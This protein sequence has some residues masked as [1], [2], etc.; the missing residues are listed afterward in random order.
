MSTFKRGDLV[1]FTDRQGIALETRVRRVEIIRGTRYYA[2][3]GVG[4]MVPDGL[5]AR[6]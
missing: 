6:A 3:D 2:L 5:E 4:V 1:T